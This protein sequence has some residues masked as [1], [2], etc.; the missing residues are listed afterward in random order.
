M[1]G[2]L[3]LTGHLGQRGEAGF[4]FRVGGDVVRHLAVV[5]LFVGHHVEVAGA[6]QAEDNGLATR[7]AWLDSGAGRMPSIRANCSA[8]SKTLVCS[9]DTASM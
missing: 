7:M 6:R 3:V 9:T 2:A 1:E 4:Q 8:A 5:E